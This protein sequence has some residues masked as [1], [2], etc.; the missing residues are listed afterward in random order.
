M[1]QA[2][3]IANTQGLGATPASGDFLRVASVLQVPPAQAAQ[4]VQAVA[5]TGNIGAQLA[6]SLQAGLAQITLP[7]GAQL[8]NAG[9]QQA[10][11]GLERAAQ[12][13]VAHAPQN[14]A[15]SEPS[16]EMVQADLQAQIQPQINTGDGA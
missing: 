7:N 9:I 10:V 1:K 5:T 15:R 11:Q 13:L 6:S 3:Q 14:T 2:T 8:D 4:V 16:A 12:A